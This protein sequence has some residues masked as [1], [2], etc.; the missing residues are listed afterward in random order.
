MTLELMI[1]TVKEKE[2][3]R[4]WTIEMVRELFT[5][6]SRITSGVRRMVDQK[7]HRSLRKTSNRVNSKE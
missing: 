4:P 3:G 5:Q 1:M 7:E 6:S 2:V